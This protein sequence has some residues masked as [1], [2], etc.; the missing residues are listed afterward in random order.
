M[1]API[2]IRNQLLKE[3]SLPENSTQQEII[4]TINFLADERLIELFNKFWKGSKAQFCHYYN[5]NFSNF[6]R[7]SNSKKE[8]IKSRE[9]VQGYLLSIINGETIKSIGL[10]YNQIDYKSYLYPSNYYDYVKDWDKLLENLY[11]R[12]IDIFIILDGDQTIKEIKRL[13]WIFDESRTNIHI[14]LFGG[15]N[16]QIPSFWVDTYYCSWIRCQNNLP[17]AT[18]LTISMALKELHNYEL[19]LFG[20]PK[21]D[22]IIVSRDYF[23]KTLEAIFKAFSR[24]IIWVDHS[25]CDIGLY[26]LFYIIANS[27]PC[28]LSLLGVKVFEF[29]KRIVTDIIYENFKTDAQLLKEIF[30]LNLPMDSICANRIN[31]INMRKLEESIISYLSKNQIIGNNSG[32]KENAIEKCVKNG[33][34]G[35]ENDGDDIIKI[36]SSLPEIKE[37]K[38][39]LKEKDTIT[40]SSLGSKIF[41]SDT[42]KE[43]AKSE[44][45][46]DILRNPIVSEIL[47]TELINVH[48]TYYLVRN[49]QTT[50]KLDVSSSEI[51]RKR[52]LTEWPNSPQE[53]CVLYKINKGN[54][55]AFIKGRKNDPA[56]CAAIRKW[57]SES[58]RFG[59]QKDPERK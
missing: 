13:S 44:K 42:L 5:T 22:I 37:I 27:I 45:L 11:K 55:N 14:L 31:L 51:L 53:F 16:L 4:N 43:L 54:F 36:I 23:A 57:L 1:E 39:L 3:L 46:T 17:Q 2:N 12:N 58:S 48:T 30:L 40:I 52:F 59:F 50:N 49:N 28:I 24:R 21:K 10:S 56:S 29:I 38:E 9:S 33:E 6:S 25:S 35:K 20:Q 41:I 47:D 18:D 19:K 7:W 26:L 15:S 8:S 34:I 32:I